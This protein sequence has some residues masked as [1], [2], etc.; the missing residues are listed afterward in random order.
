MIEPDTDTPQERGDDNVE[1][2]KGMMDQT[3]DKNVAVMDAL[4]DG[5]LPKTTD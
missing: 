5:E 1:M 4:K 2:T 3:N